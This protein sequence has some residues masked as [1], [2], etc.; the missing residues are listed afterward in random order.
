MAPLRVVPRALDEGPD[1]VLGEAAEDEDKQEPGAWMIQ[2]A[3]PEQ[4]IEDPVGAQRP[5]DRDDQTAAEDF[6]DAG[7]PVDSILAPVALA[8]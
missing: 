4:H 2:S 8:M 7:A 6:A 5:T 3:Q 1:V